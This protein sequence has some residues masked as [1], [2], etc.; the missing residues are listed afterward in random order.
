MRATR[1]LI[2]ILF[3]SF[4]VRVF[5]AYSGGQDFWPDESRYQGAQYAVLHLAHGEW[6]LAAGDLLGHADHLL[7]RWF[8]LP[9]ALGEYLAG[10]HPHL[11]ACYFSLFSILAIWLVW[12]VA[13]RAGA[14]EREALTA[15]FLAACSNSLFYY[16]RHYFPYDISLCLMLLA[17]YVGLGSWS[18]RR[19]LT[20]G[21]L[22]GLGFLTY[23]GYWWLGGTILA[24]H[25]LLAPGGGRRG[26]ARA[27]WAGLGLVLPIAL[28]VAAAGAFG[29]NLVSGYRQ[30]A[31]S[32]TQGDFGLGYRV[33]TEYLWSSEGLLLVVWLAG[34][35]LGAW[36]SVRESW[37]HRSRWWLGALVFICA[38]YLLFSDVFHKFVV[39]GRQVRVVVP[40]FCLITAYAVEQLAARRVVRRGV[41]LASLAAVLG[42]AAWNFSGP[43]TQM[44]P[45]QFPHRAAAAVFHRQQR[46][47]PGLYRMQFAQRLD[48][49]NLPV[50][51]PSHRVVLRR[52]NP[53]QYR[54]YQFE[55]FT[56]R[57]RRALNTHDISM[58]VV[59]LAGPGSRVDLPRQAS[60]WGDYPGPV[61]MTLK[62]PPAGA[63]GGQP[64][65][66]SG[67][68]YHGDFLYLKVE[69]DH[70]IRFGYDDWGGGS[71]V[72]APMVVDPT[73]SHELI[74]SMG[75][76][77]P[78]DRPEGSGT[79]K[80]TPLRDYLLV[81]LD[82]R[83]V[84]SRRAPYHP[85]RAATITYGADL[86]GGSSTV[87]D[88]HGSILRI[89]R[90]E[91]SDVEAKIGPLAA[92]AVAALRPADWEGAVG[93]VQM[94]VA[95]P[96]GPAGEAQPLVATGRPGQGGLVYWLRDPDGRIRL[97][98]V[99]SGSGAV[100]S[101]PLTLRSADKVRFVISLGSMMPPAGS[102]YYREHAGDRRLQDL[103][104]ISVDGH[105]GLLVN[106]PYDGPAKQVTFAANAISNPAAM[107]YFSGDVLAIHPADP[108]KVLPDSLRLA[109]MVEP[110]GDDWAGYPGPTKL[111]LRFYG[112]QADPG[113]EPIVVS[114]VSGRGDFLYVRSAGPGRLQIG[115][116]H[117]G[118][119]GGLSQPIAFDPK[120]PHEIAF[121]MGSLMPE[122]PAF[123]EAHPELAQLRNLLW[124]TFDGQPV[125]AR[126]E[127]FHP[128]RPGEIT[129][130]ANR[131]GGSTC[132]PNLKALILEVDP[133]SMTGIRK[134]ILGLVAGR[135]SAAGGDWLGHSGP[136]TMKVQIPDLPR[137]SA[138]PLL[139]TGRTGAGDCLSLRRD[140]DGRFRLGFDH[141]GI[142]EMLLSEPFPLQVGS[143][144]TFTVSIGSLYPASSSA[145]FVAHPEW[146]KL[147]T[148]VFV[149]LD[150]RTV[151]Q[152]RRAAFTSP[153]ASV[154]YG[155]NR[156]GISTAGRLFSGRI[157][158][159][160]SVPVTEILHGHQPAK[161]G[162]APGAR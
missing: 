92:P 152:G 27:G 85:A 47:G 97:G 157:T 8:G 115:F 69:A 103:V 28:C 105:F 46:E 150:G 88:F 131:I 125:F 83:T 134:R 61:R 98:Y 36:L 72:S 75:S 158:D 120:V 48:P 55:G 154:D 86:I 50:A 70:R 149:L 121:S 102:R 159:V 135:P 33:M 160:K 89:E 119:G 82:G 112:E 91:L 60:P 127:E 100:L 81:A 151:L 5:L 62:L 53:L 23:N 34:A 1:L 124:V 104:C 40:F 96:S 113:G 162:P 99:H 90:A 93:P 14:G 10:P 128:S 15:A 144:H 139:T 77:Y 71:F 118:G 38:G 39:Y 49:T 132:G 2:V 122:D 16:S 161:A 18:W 68:P 21:V 114:G 31:G 22:A 54:P 43:L 140:A 58:R 65:V 12:L 116:D 25:T 106:R 20:A 41:W 32:V 101:D 80:L 42:M 117:W 57:Q 109:N 44:F 73:R 84:F 29:F 59:Q 138:E 45:A 4:G 141:W 11:V 17:L 24:L 26:P 63:V 78:P 35:T 110:R 13:R 130:G 19:S 6:Q 133:L 142:R 76:L 64:L 148:E 37:T 136:V 66:T 3:L 153:P 56:Q 129:V 146:R 107:A 155:E 30:F 74:V 143:V 87:P 9:P 67:V 111:R 145:L 147:L 126:A 123:Y 94:D 95:L 156:I 79:A 7:F 52:R 51:S 137:G 108:V